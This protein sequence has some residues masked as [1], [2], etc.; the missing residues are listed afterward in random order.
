MANQR[1]IR[2]LRRLFLVA[3]TII[4]V[5]VAAEGL[6]RR[7]FGLHD[8]VLLRTDP[9]YEYIAQAGQVRERFGNR[10]AY[11]SLSMRSP[12]PDSSA[13]IL[14]GCGDSVINGG[15][16]TDQD[17]LATTVVSRILSD[18]LARPVQFLNISAGSWGPGNCAAYLGH[19]PLPQARGLVLFV[20]S[21]DAH[22]YMTFEPVVGTNPDFPDKQ[23]PLALVELVQRYMLPRLLNEKPTASGLGIHKGTGSLDPGFME[24]KRWADAHGIPMVIH[25][26][27]ELSEVKA[28]RYNAQG[29]EIIRFAREQGIPLVRDLDHGIGPGDFRD[30]IHFN[31]AGQRAL[32]GILLGDIHARPGDY[33]LR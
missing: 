1:G 21:H 2:R 22:D 8:M 10:I 3:G 14:L 9:Y 12:E 17:S 28:G 18:S 30:M 24:L 7:V 32:A 33:G 19:T 26:H 4:L 27:A 13:I 25:L 16:L 6:L 29:R 20:S 5:L 31:D 11:N 15:T 23:Y